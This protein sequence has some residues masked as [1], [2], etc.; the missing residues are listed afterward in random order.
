MPNAQASAPKPLTP[1]AAPRRSAASEARLRRAHEGYIS[2]MLLTK[3][4]RRRAAAATA[5]STA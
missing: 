3:A 5:V 1:T 2:S 4:R